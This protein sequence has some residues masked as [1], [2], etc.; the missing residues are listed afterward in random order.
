MEAVCYQAPRKVERITAPIPTIQ[1]DQV[2]IKAEQRTSPV[3]CCGICGTDYHLA[4]GEFMA[5]FPLI[6]GHEIVGFVLEIGKDVKGLETGDRCVVDNTI[7]CDDCHYCRRAEYLYCEN[8]E[9][10]GVTMGG[11]FAEYVAV[12]AKKVYKINNLTDQEATLVEPTAC[13]IHGM[14]K[15]SPPVGVE[16]LILGAGPTGIS[17]KTQIAKD[18]NL[19]DEYFELDRVDA[20]AQFQEL[21]RRHPRGFDVVAEGTAVDLQIEATGSERVANN[22]IDYVRR[23]GTLMIYGVYSNDARVHWSPAK[24]F[25]DEIRIIGS[26]AQTHCFPRAVDYLE[27]G[28]I[29]VKPLMRKDPEVGTK[30]VTDSFTIREYPQALEKLN[31]KTACKIVVTP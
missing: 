7:F 28:K 8:W 15:L 23:G 3:T 14:D 9:S 13:A 16:V 30:Q 25:G 4:E 1:D 20:S 11:G 10:L 31:S 6:P 24:I 26:F 21:K 18:M 12:Q 27:R 19:A 5:K 17:S 22:A 2:L 29:N